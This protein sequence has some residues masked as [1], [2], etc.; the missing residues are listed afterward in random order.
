MDIFWEKTSGNYLITRTLISATQK[1]YPK[2]ADFN[3][4]NSAFL[5]FKIIFKIFILSEA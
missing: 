1:I 3:F 2:T 4:E 5:R